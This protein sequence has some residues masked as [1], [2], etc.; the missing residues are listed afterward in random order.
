MYQRDELEEK[1]YTVST[2]NVA[3][4]WMCTLEWHNRVAT[5]FGATEAESLKQAGRYV[6]D[7]ERK[8]LLQQQRLRCEGSGDV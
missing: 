8:Y 3:I 5:F 7:M 4:S 6:A 2:K 1:G